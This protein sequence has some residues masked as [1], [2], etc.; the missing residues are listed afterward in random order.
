MR[1][2]PKIVAGIGLLAVIVLAG[3]ALGWLGS[4]GTAPEAKPLPPIQPLADS[5]PA[6]PLPSPTAI[7]HAPVYRPVNTNPPPREWTTAAPATVS[8]NGAADWEDKVDNILD[9]SDDDT[10]KVKQLFA[11]FPNLPEEGKVEVAQHL[12]NLV[13]DENYAPLGKMLEDSALPEDVQDVLMADLLNRPN[14]VKLPLFLDL[15]RSPDNAKS[16]E[17]RD[18]LE[19]YLDEDYGT[20]WAKWQEKIQEWLKD[21]PD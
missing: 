2:T 9:S 16:G 7:E 11:M 1:N 4:R 3:L 19:L 6:N 20:D 10:N 5:T 13:P 15:A 14:A 18:L 21:N 8:T 12:S 17:A